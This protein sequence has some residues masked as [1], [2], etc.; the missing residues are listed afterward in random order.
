MLEKVENT[1][2]FEI[3]IK[4]SLNFVDPEIASAASAQFFHFISIKY[5]SGT[6]ELPSLKRILLQLTV[7]RYVIRINKLIWPPIWLHFRKFLDIEKLKRHQKRR[8][9]DTT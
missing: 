1:F 8:F 2:E 5:E 3:E 6:I 7:S 4:I 9:T